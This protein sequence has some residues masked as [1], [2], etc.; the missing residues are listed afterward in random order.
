MPHRRFLRPIFISAF[1]AIILS[2]LA[3]TGLSASDI[4]GHYQHPLRP[5]IHY[6]TIIQNEDDGMEWNDSFWMKSGLD[7]EAAFNYIGIKSQDAVDIGLRFHLEDL[8][9]GDR[10][11]LARLRFITTDARIDSGVVLKISGVDLNSAPAFSQ[12]RRPSKAKYL[13]QN[14]LVW[15]PFIWPVYDPPGEDHD[16]MPIR[17]PLYFFSPNIAP[18]INEILARPGWG[19]GP[20]GKTAAILIDNKAPVSS[21]TNLIAFQDFYRS[22]STHPPAVLELYAS[23]IDTFLG[24]PVLGRPTAE[25]VSISLGPQMGSEFYIEYGICRGVY[26]QA[27]GATRSDLPTFDPVTSC[28]PGS[29]MTLVLR[30]LMPDTQYYYRLRARLSG[31]D[32]VYEASPEYTF[33]TQ[34]SPGETFT[35]AF[36]S[37]SHIGMSRRPYSPAWDLA[38]RSIENAMAESPDLFIIGGDD[39][40]TYEGQGLYAAQSPY[41]A[42]LRYILLR[43]Y[44]GPLANIA[45]LFLVLGNHEGEGGYYDFSEYQFNLQQLSYQARN[46][47]TLNPTNL[48]YPFGGGLSQNYYAWEWGD[49]LFVVIDPFTYTGPED[50]M[51]VEPYGSA[52]TL[53]TGQLSWLENVL[54]TSQARWKFVFSHH[55]LASYTKNGYAHGGAKYAHDWEQGVIHEMMR[56]HG[57]QIFFYGH[58]HVFADGKAD[59]IHYTCAPMCAGIN[60]VAWAANPDSPKYPYFVDA[61]PY[62]FFAERGFVRVK[63]GPR[64]VWVD[65]VKSALEETEN[66]EVIY[67]YHMADVTV[68]LIPP[69]MQNPD[70]RILTGLPP[71]MDLEGN[72]QMGLNRVPVSVLFTNHQDSPQ[73]VDAWIKAVLPGGQEITCTVQEELQIEGGQ[74]LAADYDIFI[75]LDAGQ[76]TIVAKIGDYPSQVISVDS[77]SP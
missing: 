14:R 71:G 75:P 11:T 26:T 37:D 76:Y 38:H 43:H 46:K 16:H 54:S 17:S 35:F 32:G 25:E 30:D 22:S 31:D 59:G 72:H 3:T 13:T 15:K 77:F 10:F 40:M 47:L 58:D 48:T 19:T 57:A 68:K 29:T 74:S 34:R 28:P 45:P 33:R 64:S 6:Y 9:Q 20:E 62:G 49:A 60:P 61:Y 63:V 42:E 21:E 44:Y 65:F 24:G 70:S 39:A 1:S 23:V 55:I 56:D 67:G 5:G 2:S 4:A 73:T 18:I 50:P 7:S 53:G 36:L 51:H 8:N 27:V 66:G 41:D 12:D 69:S 52:W